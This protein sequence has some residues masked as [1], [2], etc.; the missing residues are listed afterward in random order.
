MSRYVPVLGVVAARAVA[1]R[2]G[3]G[4]APEGLSDRQHV[5]ARVARGLRS[6]STLL[7]S[8]VLVLALGAGAGAVVAT[9]SRDALLSALGVGGVAE[10]PCAS[11]APTLAAAFE[12]AVRCGHEVAA[13]DSYDAW[14]AKWAQPD[15]VAVRWESS[16]APVRAETDGGT[17]TAVD[18]TIETVD[19][20]GDGRLN[21]AAPVYDVSFAA[22]DDEP[23][24]R[25]ESG[26]HWLE[27]DVPFALTAPVVEGDQVTYPGILDDDG[28][29]LIVSADA[30]GTGFDDVI[31]VADEQ[32]A[33][34]PALKELTFG[35]EVSAGLTL[36]GE[37]NGFVAVDED[38]EEIFT[39]P[40]PLMWGEP[41]GGGV[42]DPAGGPAAEE[43]PVVGLDAQP[44]SA[45]TG[46]DG[47]PDERNES[48]DGPMVEGGVAEL[49]AV[50]ERR[51][52]STATV[53]IVPD[54]GM[55][56]GEGV[57]FP[58]A[59]DPSVSGVSLNEWAGVKSRWPDSN[60][61]YKFQDR[62]AGDHGVGLCDPS[63]GYGDDCGLRSYHRVLYEFNVS[64]VGKLN[65]SDITG[66][67]FS[68]S[69]VHAA[70]CST[71]ATAV[72]RIG[73]NKVS[74]STTWNTKGSWGTRVAS[75]GTNHRDGCT[76]RKVRIGYAVTSSAKKVASSGWNYLTLG[77]K[78]DESSMN[79]WKRYA[80]S[81]YG[82]NYDHGATLSVTYNRP[83]NTPKYLHTYEG[84]EN[85]WC[86]SSAG[87]PYLS[88][89]RPKLSAYIK[90]PDATQ[91]RGRFQ[92]YRVSNGTKVWGKYSS[93]KTSGSRHTLQL[94]SGEL[95]S[96]VKYRWRVAAQDSS[97]KQGPWS[98]WCHFIPDIVAPNTPTI[99]VVPGQPAEYHQNV[100]T[101]GAGVTG[102]FKLGRNGS[103]DVSRFEYSFGTDT[104]GKKVSVGS[105]GYAT[106][107]FNP[108]KP[109]PTTLYVRS[110]D[111]AGNPSVG[112]RTWS[113]DVAYP[114]AN[115][116]WMLDEG[117]G[118]DAADSSG[119]PNP[120]PMEF[121]PGTDPP[122]W[123]AGPHELFGSR[124][125]DHALE[126]N[127]VDN[128]IFRWAPLVDTTGSFVVSAHVRL[129]ER[130]ATQ[131]AVSQDADR[132]SGFKLGYRGDCA[133]TPA[134]DCWGF[135]MFES[136]V[137]S[138]AAVHAI[139]G[140]EPVT[141]EWVH[142]TGAYNAVSDEISLWV[143][144]VGTPEAP[145]PGE[146]VRTTTP[147]ANPTP[148]QADGPFV[149][150][151][152]K[153][154]GEQR[155]FWNGAI[156]NVRVFDGQIVAEA[157]IRRLCQ[158]AE[159]RAFEAG[160]EGLEDGKIALDPTIKDPEQ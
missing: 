89:V 156:D 41:E 32:A 151:R 137:D 149:I 140:V 37:G 79:A 87:A 71:T 67:E 99:E 80:G 65:S 124:D 51:G 91:V 110:R 45:A 78:A 146:P 155:D 13:E 59:I 141:G 6:R 153:Y 49:P 56:A 107:S 11:S 76:G 96:N 43:S 70:T 139:S 111:K 131:V 133:G 83:P 114:Q 88:T 50:V 39:S 60:S 106:I 98:E 48:F 23:L 142:L 157:K 18:R 100:E 109:G 104:M 44:R 138:P 116:I 118:T 53:T 14:S 57:D 92:V 136:D 113:I 135:W 73:A 154:R 108:S 29:D 2:A 38:G 101:G 75:Q 97:G 36:Q 150:G 74:S 19:V 34:N 72:Y 95:S 7:V 121:R 90:D 47:A 22:R 159:A 86:A 1:V 4:M 8:G 82:S 128:R 30:Q 127:G 130:G 102:K 26:E 144:P 93:Y 132:T 15:G 129:A 27:F 143:C 54:A 125:G 66:A 147:F 46:E 115:G 81:R 77:L 122:Q 3:A 40:V 17:W 63:S 103:T 35:V 25:V 58:L 10:E 123:V 94:P 117:T 126:F 20:D 64:N 85:K 52:S 105:D 21:V 33:Q 84:S 134:G 24:A 120:D 160:P 9:D 112:R 31:R 61:A 158:G 145:K 62:E 55:L 152:S 42:A 16:A 5:M 68:V 148:W 69:G 119:V 12:M 28:L